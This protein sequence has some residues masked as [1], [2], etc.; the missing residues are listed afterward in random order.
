MKHYLIIPLLL[1]M[2]TFSIAEAQEKR[3]RAERNTE[4]RESFE[5]QRLEISQERNVLQ[6]ERN[7]RKN[8]LREAL[9]NAD[10]QEE[11]EA[12]LEEAR[13]LREQGKEEGSA[14]R[15]SI[16][17]QASELADRKASLVV[18]RYDAV[19]NRI[20]NITTRLEQKIQTLNEEGFDVGEAQASINLITSSLEE[21]ENAFQQGQEIFESV[22]RET[23]EQDE[24][25]LIINSARE[26]LKTS[27]KAIKKAWDQAKETVTILKSL[28]KTTTDA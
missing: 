7:N 15:E 28:S 23:M 26:S 19:M 11:R 16:H 20:G 3:T 22:D 1:G 12:I 5:A 2:I 27:K 24:V 17:S 6:E 14:L 9:E 25:K 10:T 13:I 4:Q 18:D 21:A 8:E